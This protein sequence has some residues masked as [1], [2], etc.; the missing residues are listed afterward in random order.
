VIRILDSTLKRLAILQSIETANRFEEINGENKL[1]FTAVYDEKTAQYVNE[2]AVVELDN[3]YFDIVYYAKQQIDS[4]VLAMQV[5][6]EHVSYRLNRPEYNLDLFTA[7]GTPTAVLTQ[8]L[9][10]T[11]F[12][13]GTVEYTAP[14]TY[15]AQEAKSRRQ[16]LMEFVGVLGGEVDFDKFTVSIVVHRGSTTRKLLAKGKNI[17]VV[18][19][20]YDGRQKDKA[21][22]PLVS[23]TCTPIQLPN[24]PFAAGD[25]VLLIQKDL[26]IQ[27]PHRIVRLGYNPYDNIEASIELANFVSG[28]EDTFY[29]IE[30]QK[31]TADKLYYGARIGPEF[32]FES[33][34]SD[35]K[36]RAYFNADA[37]K[38]QSGDGTGSNWTDKLYFDPATGEYIFDGKLTITN[39]GQ[40]LAEIYKDVNGGRLK[41]YDANGQLNAMIGVESGTSTNTGGTFALYKDVP[42]GADPIPY[43]R[44]EAGIYKANHSGIFN[45]RDDNNII[46]AFLYANH[47]TYGPYMGVMNSDGTVPLSYLSQTEGKINGKPILTQN[48]VITQLANGCYLEALSDGLRMHLSSSTYLYIGTAGCI[49]YVNGIPTT[50]A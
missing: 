2:T 16:L 18:S 35:K 34:R 33:I 47:P 48:G 30:T 32:G 3:D 12:T 22:N 10:G 44:V 17:K 11:P 37:F 50:L 7:T 9:A 25:D 31:V 26:G 36:A 23:Y 20:I 13:V 41:I 15:S 29:R 42:Q 49:A 21:G 27:E 14:I 19:K 24:T 4:G 39:L 5:Q 38:M 6:S 40:L 43:Q 45:L 28:L 1:D 8:L 46:R